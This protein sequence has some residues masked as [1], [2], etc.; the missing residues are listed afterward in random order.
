MSKIPTTFHIKNT[1]EFITKLA[2]KFS[3]D[4]TKRPN[5]YQVVNKS[6]QKSALFPTVKPSPAEGKSAATVSENPATLGKGMRVT[7]A[8]WNKYQDLDAKKY[9]FWTVERI[10]LSTVLEFSSLSLTNFSSFFSLMRTNVLA[11][12]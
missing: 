10:K 11:N 1:A 12:L 2:T 8:S 3:K 5:L 6:I 4:A 9:C 7:R